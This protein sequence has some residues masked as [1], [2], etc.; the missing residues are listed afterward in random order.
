MPQKVNEYLKK[1]QFSSGF[2]TI[3][4]K[5]DICLYLD[6]PSLFEIRG[7]EDNIMG[8]IHCEDI[9]EKFDSRFGTVENME[10]ASDI[11]SAFRFTRIHL[12]LDD[13]PEFALEEITVTTEDKVLYVVNKFLD[14][15][16]LVTRRF[17]IE[18]IYSLSGLPELNVLR[19]QPGKNSQG[20]QKI[21]FS[22]GMTTLKPMRSQ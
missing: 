15:Y 18:N 1:S 17:G 4:F 6:E 7:V 8:L 12:I 9:V 13:Q 10:L 3:S 16:K 22:G 14:S 11:R 5:L 2:L 21:Q 19:Y 20:L